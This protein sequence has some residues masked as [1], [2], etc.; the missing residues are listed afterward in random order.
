MLLRPPL[1]P[2]CRP[3]LTAPC[4][5]LAALPAGP[6]RQILERLRAK[7]A[8]EAGVDLEHL[9]ARSDRYTGADLANLAQ[10]AALLALQESRDAPCIAA[11]H[12]D[13]AL[14]SMTPS[15]THAMLRHLE[16]WGQTHGKS[17]R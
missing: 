5:P 6:H 9:V 11:K 12:F 2:A 17:R 16:Q 1:P 3:P 8:W 10:R 15:T 14:L 13:T 4:P 7:M